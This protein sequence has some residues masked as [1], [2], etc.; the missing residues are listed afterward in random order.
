MARID[1]RSF[2]LLMSRMFFECDGLR[3]RLAVGANLKNRET[4]GAVGKLV[5]IVQSQNH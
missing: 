1:V 5:A 4:L 3:S 2:D